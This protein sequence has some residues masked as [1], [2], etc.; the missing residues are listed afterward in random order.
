MLLADETYEELIDTSETVCQR[1]FECVDPAPAPE[2][3]CWSLVQM[4]RSF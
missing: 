2:Q 3:T 4:C 1:T